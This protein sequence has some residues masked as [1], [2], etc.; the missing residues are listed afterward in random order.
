[1]VL[2]KL[3][4]GKG[5]FVGDVRIRYLIIGVMGVFFKKQYLYV[6]RLCCSHGPRAWILEC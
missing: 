3:G 1:M 2:F 5:R 4:Q 6:W